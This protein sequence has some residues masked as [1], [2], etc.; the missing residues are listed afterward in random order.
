MSERRERA[1][2]L[3]SGASTGSGEGGTASPAARA[4]RCRLCRLVPGPSTM[5]SNRAA[6][7]SH[8]SP[9]WRNHAFGHVM[10]ES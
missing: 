8:V 4:H 5:I 2:P 9:G 6:C 3:G 1:F 10:W 7:W